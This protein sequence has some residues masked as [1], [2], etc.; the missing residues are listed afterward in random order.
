M[1]K[2]LDYIHVEE[3]IVQGDWRSYAY[4]HDDEG[5]PWKLRGYGKTPE[6]AA[7]DA[8]E[9]Y[10]DDCDNWFLHGERKEHDR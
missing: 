6:Q 10:L 3:K 7:K 9:C 2:R 4:C 8:H 5:K 1:T